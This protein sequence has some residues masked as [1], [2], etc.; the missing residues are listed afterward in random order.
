MG[1]CNGGGGGGGGGD[2]PR[3]PKHGSWALDYAAKHPGLEEQSA[4]PAAPCLLWKLRDSAL[5]SGNYPDYMPATSA[6]LDE[7]VAVK[8]QDTGQERDPM[9]SSVIPRLCGRAGCKQVC[10]IVLGSGGGG[11]MD[12][13][14]SINYD[15]QPLVCPPALPSAVSWGIRGSDHNPV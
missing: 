14:H 4:D 13:A 11:K 2:G 6:L 9:E 10:D 5:R 3:S 12:G 8:V 1:M 15:D 7:T